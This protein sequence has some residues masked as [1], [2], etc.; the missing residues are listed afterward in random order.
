MGHRTANE[1]G[2]D[3]GTSNK[4]LLSDCVVKLS[5]NS[6][7]ILDINNITGNEF[8]T[9]ICEQHNNTASEKLTIHL[10]GSFMNNIF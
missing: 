2:K 8:G 9:Y 10:Q 3:N 6:S 1:I 5:D 7:L 4:P